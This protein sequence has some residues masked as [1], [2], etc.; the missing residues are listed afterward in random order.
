MEKLPAEVVVIIMRSIDDL[1]AL[2]ALIST[3]SYLYNTFTTLKFTILESVLRQAVGDLLPFAYC[4][5]S[6]PTLYQH[7]ISDDH[8]YE[9]IIARYDD[10]LGRHRRMA[11]LPMNSPPALLVSICKL[12]NC[13][14]AWT[15]RLWQSVAVD[16]D[17]RG[18]GRECH[19]ALTTK[20]STK[21]GEVASRKPVD[22][23][24]QVEANYSKVTCRGHNVPSREEA[25]RIHRAFYRFE[26]Y[27]RIFGPRALVLGHRGSLWD[28]FF[29]DWPPWEIEEFFCVYQFLQHQ[30]KARNDSPFRSWYGKNVRLRGMRRC[31][32]TTSAG[33]PPTYTNLY[34][35]LEQANKIFDRWTVRYT[36][37]D[38][39]ED[40]PAK[41]VHDCMQSRAT[42]RGALLPTFQRAHERRDETSPSFCWRWLHDHHDH[43]LL[44]DFE[45]F[46]DWG[47]VFWDEARCRIWG[48]GTIPFRWEDYAHQIQEVLHRGTIFRM[49]TAHIKQAEAI[50][51]AFGLYGD[52]T[53][54]LA[55]IHFPEGITEELHEAFLEFFGDI[56]FDHCRYCEHPA[57]E[58]PRA[59]LNDETYLD[60]FIRKKDLSLVR[61]LEAG[62]KWRIC[63]WR[64]EVRKWCPT[65]FQRFYTIFSRFA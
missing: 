1:S 47:Y 33:S 62:T 63:S 11:P 49:K 7:A 56:D 26:L 38:E 60:V 4:A 28:T 45:W 17:F 64:K 12:H 21:S 54:T 65:T 13:V 20:I 52:W 59:I 14:M 10:I 57:D 61:W 5:A 16:H 15:E 2:H 40:L 3:S 19:C 9:M 50:C 6:D 8:P 46:R 48:F 29:I 23:A 41:V 31:G 43:F 34:M 27:S 39:V 36:Y 30:F 22:S 58:A 18:P 55:L 37:M 32:P 51:Y 53:P 42:L 44:D 24:R 25:F 35:G